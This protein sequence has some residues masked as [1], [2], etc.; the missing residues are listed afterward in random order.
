M[1]LSANHGTANLESG[2]KDHNTPHRAEIDPMM[3]AKLAV[4]RKLKNFVLTIVF[5][6]LDRFF[7]TFI[8]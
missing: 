4:S 7:I 6:N 8:F 2:W 3:D 5:D 1:Q